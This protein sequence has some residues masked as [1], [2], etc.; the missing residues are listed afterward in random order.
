MRWAWAKT[1]SRVRT[2]CRQ[3][4]AG[5]WTALLVMVIVLKVSSGAAEAPRAVVLEIDGVIGPAIANYIVREF[6][7]IKASDTRL[8]I[9]RINT[10]GGLDTSMREIIGAILSSPVPVAAYV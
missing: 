7:E 1:L 5:F 3:C 4:R 6:H 10:P 9:L 2:H 8:V